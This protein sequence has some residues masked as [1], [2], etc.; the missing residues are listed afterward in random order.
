MPGQKQTPPIAGDIAAAADVAV[1]TK[2]GSLSATL[3]KPL[4]D[5]LGEVGDHLAGA[6]L[7]FESGQAV[8]L[9]SAGPGGAASRPV[10]VSR[11]GRN[12][13]EIEI[14]SG[15]DEAIDDV[16]AAFLALKI[17]Q[18]KKGQLD[19]LPA[20]T[21]EDWQAETDDAFKAAEAAAKARHGGG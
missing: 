16:T 2:G 19:L 13:F 6:A 18:F 15:E 20:V 4:R 11:V 5:T 12:R 8:V 10:H 9:L 17:D 14:D 3:K 1:N 21:A 7:Q